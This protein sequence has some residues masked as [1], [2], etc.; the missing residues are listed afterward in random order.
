MGTLPT[1]TESSVPAA[2]TDAQGFPFIM[3][4]KFCN[5]TGKVSDVSKWPPVA[6]CPGCHGAGVH[7]LR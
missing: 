7:V 2:I 1:R 3:P 4:C 6:P 5:S